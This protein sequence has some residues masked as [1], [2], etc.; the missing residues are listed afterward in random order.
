M[1]QILLPDLPEQKGKKISDKCY[2]IDDELTRCILVNDIPVYLYDL[3]DKVAERQVCVNLYRNGLATQLELANAV[4]VTARTVRNWVRSYRDNGAAGLINKQRPGAPIKLTGELKK[5]IKRYRRERMK[6]TKIAQV[7]NLSLGT[8]CGF[9]Y[10][11]KQKSPELFVEE[12]PPVCDHAAELS[13]TQSDLI[14]TT[15]DVNNLAVIIDK[16]SDGVSENAADG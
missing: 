14:C 5:K 6:V 4:N 8:I 9:L 7:M 16:D 1:Q 2:Y 11:S 3:A 10:S 13:E 12:E 15:E